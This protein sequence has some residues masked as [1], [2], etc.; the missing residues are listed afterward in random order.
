M[1]YVNPILP[2]HVF[3][4]VN[5][6]YTIIK[7]YRQY[8]LCL[9]KMSDESWNTVHHDDNIENLLKDYFD[10]RLSLVTR[11]GEPV[12][13]KEP[14][15]KLCERYK[16]MVLSDDSNSYI[17]VEGGIPRETQYYTLFMFNG[18]GYNATNPSHKD[19]NGSLNDE[20]LSGLGLRTN[21]GEKVK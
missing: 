19:K 1:K 18:K 16:G 2:G 11:L 7:N 10:D 5:N 4:C 13:E 21:Y 6:T 14:T 15:Y 17:L 20:I 9:Y 3:H 12:F 8:N